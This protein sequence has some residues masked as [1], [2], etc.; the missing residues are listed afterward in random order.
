[1][2]TEIA[3]RLWN[4]FDQGKAL[5]PDDPAA[6]LAGKARRLESFT[7][8]QVDQAWTRVESW[9]GRSFESGEIMQAE[10]TS[11]LRIS[12][13]PALTWDGLGMEKNETALHQQLSDLLDRVR[14]RRVF[15]PKASRY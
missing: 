3:E 6:I 11:G 15:T 14:F 9:R 13:R 1:M 12:D 7:G 10:A 8:R 5:F 2:S 4:A